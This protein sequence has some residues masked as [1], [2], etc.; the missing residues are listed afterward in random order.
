M[1]LRE[2]QGSTAAELARDICHDAGSLTRIIDEL[3]RRELVTRQRSAADRRV[4]TLALSPRGGA[5][6]ESLMPRVVEFWNR[7]LGGF[8]HGEIR[9]LIKLLTRLVGA[10]GGAGEDLSPRRR[11]LL[12]KLDDHHEHQAGHHRDHHRRRRV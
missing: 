9:Q 11:Q 10:A 7:L 3:E 8:S 5:L 2:W 4:V 6:V 12:D 1:A